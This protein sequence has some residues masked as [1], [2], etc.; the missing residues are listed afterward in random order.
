MCSKILAGVCGSG[1]ANNV[2]SIN[3]KLALPW[4]TNHQGYLRPPG[5]GIP[6][7]QVSGWRRGVAGDPSGDCA[8]EGA[9]FDGCR[10]A[11]GVES[12][13]APTRLSVFLNFFGGLKKAFFFPAILRKRVGPKSVS[14][15]RKTVSD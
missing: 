5:I 15:K 13:G 9:S 4:K 10:L 1:A 11:G 7:H 3:L 14:K 8:T 6:I 12:A 2:T